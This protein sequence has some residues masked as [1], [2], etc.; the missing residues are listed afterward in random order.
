LELLLPPGQD[1]AGFFPPADDWELATYLQFGHFT[2][3]AS[4]I[5]VSSIRLVGANS[6]E[7]P[8]SF[9]QNPPNVLNNW[10]GF[11]DLEKTDKDNFR[12]Q[13]DPCQQVGQRNVSL[14]AKAHAE[15]TGWAGGLMGHWFDHSFGLLHPVHYNNCEWGP[16]SGLTVQFYDGKA[17]GL[18]LFT[19]LTDKNHLGYCGAAGCL[20]DTSSFSYLKVVVQRVTD[21]TKAPYDALWIYWDNPAAPAFRLN[22][23]GSTMST[24]YVALQELKTPQFIGDLGTV[25]W[26]NSFGKS[27]L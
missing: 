2:G 27:F 22:P 9:A 18:K 23:V 3:S 5:L 4:K 20:V 8:P 24:T 1:R 19:P 26:L 14:I 25:S 11:L 7:L 12:L 17:N 21:N 10:G 13:V 16:Q 15:V 6:T